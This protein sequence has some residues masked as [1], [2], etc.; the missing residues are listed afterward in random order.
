MR[1]LADLIPAPLI[2][3]GDNAWLLIALHYYEQRHAGA[4]GNGKRYAELRNRIAD[5]ILELQDEDGGIYS[6]FQADGTPIGHKSTEANL[7]C[8][9]ALRDRPSVRAR[10][11][12]WLLKQMWVEDEQRFRM[13]ST[14]D[15]TPLDAVSWGVCAL[16]AEF[17]HL[18]P[19]AERSFLRT[20]RMAAT[21]RLVTGFSDFISKNRIWFEGTGQMIVAYRTAGQHEQAARFLKEMESAMIASHLHEGTAGLPCFSNDPEWEDGDR[22]I[23]VPS[24]AWYLLGKWAVNPM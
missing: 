17:A 20:A 21:G 8:Y 22:L 9:S 12:S 24:V 23:F 2:G 14:V 13:G 15:E 19:Y 1:A 3:V 4:A 5:W 16:G 6:G 7:D 11:R 10:I 18:L